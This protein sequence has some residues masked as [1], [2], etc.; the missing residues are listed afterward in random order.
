M[1][2]CWGSGAARDA[3]EILN[4]RRF[5]VNAAAAGRSAGLPAPEA[6]PAV[7]VRGAGDW[8]SGER[9]D[10]WLKGTEGRRSRKN[11]KK[12]NKKNLKQTRSSH[13]HRS[14]DSISRQLSQGAHHGWCAGVRP[15]IV[16]QHR[17]R[18]T[19]AHAQPQRIFTPSS[20]PFAATPIG[21]ASHT[22]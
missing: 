11:K 16:K 3:P 6:Q 20:C 7:G 14:L 17:L 18:S 22:I 15:Q 19:S 8:G 5:H 1:C 10:A 4:R 13:L 2:L 12:K 9:Q 21:S